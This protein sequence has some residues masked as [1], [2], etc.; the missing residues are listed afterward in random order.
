M[1]GVEMLLPV[2]NRIAMRRLRL[3]GLR[4]GLSVSLGLVGIL[5]GTAGWMHSQSQAD[6]TPKT[7]YI[8]ADLIRVGISDDSM[9]TLEYPRTQISATGPFVIRDKNTGLPVLSGNAGDIVTV[10]V[11]GNGFYLKKTGLVFATAP[12]SPLPNLNIQTVPAQGPA[13]AV[14]P[15]P[16]PLVAAPLNENHRLKI[17][18]ITRRKEIPEYRGVFEIVRAAS[19]PAK[20]TV[21]DVVS[22][23]D[24]LKAVVPNELPMRYGLEAVKA[25]AVAAR[26]YAIR[27]REKPWKTF[28]ICDSQLC[29]V[30]LGSQTETPG[31]NNAIADTEGLVGLYNGDP[32]LALFSSSH[33]GYAENYSYAF[34]DPLTKQYP[35][36]AIAYLQGGPDV[37]LPA[38][39][40]LRTE[41]GARKFWTSPD[42]RSFDVESP[43]YRW[44]K[45]WT[46]SELEATLNQGLLAV[47]KDNSTK[48][49]ISPAFRPGDSI[50][51]F[52]GITVL[53]RG[54]SG[55]AMTVAIQGSRGSW[56]VKKE[57]L[58]RKVFSKGGKM[59]PSGNV[60]FTPQKDP[61]GATIGLIANGGGFGHGVGLSQLGASWM[62][63][64]GYQFP[65]IVQHYYRGVSLGSIP[66][67]VGPGRAEK[68]VLTRF[69]VHHPKGML[70]IQQGESAAAQLPLNQAN[71]A[72][73][74]NGKP[75]KLNPS[76]FRSGIEVNAYL[77]PGQL[78]SL[79]LYPDP[80]NPQR[81][82]KAWIELYPAQPVAQVAKR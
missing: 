63:K 11:D 12:P 54:V 52:K 28:D 26:N 81:S 16:G 6:W 41:T 22:L 48:A 40:D 44:E 36:P 21:V 7:A 75:L 18:N 9:T 3:P 34:S 15:V 1:M 13:G 8:D 71:I 14:M 17:T 29:Q 5:A 32:I 45:R 57:F 51:V 59:L 39:L 70:W 38:G 20:L 49:F 77:R 73:E 37:P 24:Y 30:Y 79:M 72:I 65:Q 43:Y 58:L 23:E 66:I 74:L 62:H 80:E 50:G 68:P 64:H 76:G 46:R 4:V 55:K 35:A 60:V 42:F 2:K 19:S 56:T 33:G 82:I 67:A 61:K 10:T 78:N 47:S 27:P 69:D 31:S 53:E 25:Q